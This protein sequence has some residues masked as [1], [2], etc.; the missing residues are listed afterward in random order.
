MKKILVHTLK[1]S[2]PGAK[3][4][5]QIRLPRNVKTVTAINVTTNGFPVDSSSKRE[6]GW[7]WLRLPEMRDV[8][9]AEVLKVP[10]QEHGNATFSNI[11][12]LSFGAGN[13]WIDGGKEETFSVVVDKL[14]T[15]VEGY[16]TDQLKG[17]FTASYTVNIYLI[18]ET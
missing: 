7:L 3:V 16:Y 18:A 15:L 9:F 8:F 14:S 4:Q 10:V 12:N 17:D 13:A 2:T 11:P 5:L 1:V 6:V